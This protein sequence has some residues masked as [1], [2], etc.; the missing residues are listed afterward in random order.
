MRI[1]ATEQQAIA[2]ALVIFALQALAP[3][4]LMLEYRYE[5][6]QA[7]PWRAFSAHFVHINWTHAVINVAAWI[8]LARLF[9]DELA[10]WRHLVVIAV[11]AVGVSAWL[12]LIHPEIAWYRGLSGV[13]HGVFFAGAIA[14]T[15]TT[16]RA[17]D[18]GKSSLYLP[19]GL[20]AVGWA[21]VVAE[22]PAGSATLHADWLDAAIVPQAHL[23]GSVIGNA[24]GAMMAF[25]SRRGT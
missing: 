19:I 11:S 25:C 8:I 12:A 4:Q 16:L 20:I 14:W 22:Q 15:G 24:I 17:I 1:S 21:K 10:S 13:L 18:A 3:L 7:Q 6:I 9:A 5:L 2:G 23:A